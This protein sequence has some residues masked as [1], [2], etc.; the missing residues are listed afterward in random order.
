MPFF[1]LGFVGFDLDLI[2]F[3]FF[4]VLAAVHFA[5][6]MIRDIRC[7]MYFAFAFF[8]SLL[9]PVHRDAYHDFGKTSTF[10]RTEV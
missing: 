6:D 10:E 7:R 9:T 2:L 4:F 1:Y 3:S 5:H 8:V